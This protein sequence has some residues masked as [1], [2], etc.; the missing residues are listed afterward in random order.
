MM[1]EDEWL[2]FEAVWDPRSL[3][4]LIMTAMAMTMTTAEEIEPLLHQAAA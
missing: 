3:S 4:Y 1:E 2:S